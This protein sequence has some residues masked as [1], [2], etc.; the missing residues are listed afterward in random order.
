[1]SHIVYLGLGSN[2]GNRKV[3]LQAAVEGIEPV[4][5]LLAT[6][7]IYET[8]PWGYLNQPDFLNQVVRVDTDLSPSEL[9]V[10]LKSLETRLGRT[11]T[12]RYGPR[13]IDIDILFYDD[14]IL[15]EPGLIIPHPRIQGR[16]FVLVPLADLAPD[17]LHP[18]EG[19]SILALLK[20]VDR[21][22]IASFEE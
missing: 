18:L 2:L 7:P 15:D 19:K 20:Q 8:P 3:N 9:L 16:A 5:R 21:S 11:A 1:M 13:T 10:Y 14:L 12:V 4:A 6:S 22:E 17:M